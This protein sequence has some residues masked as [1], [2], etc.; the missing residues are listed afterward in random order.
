MLNPQAPTFDKDQVLNFLLYHATQETRLQLIQEL[1]AAYARVTGGGP[2]TVL[3]SGEVKA[4]TDEIDALRR[5][6]FPDV[7]LARIRNGEAA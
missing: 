2:Y 3:R 5:N 6:S 7:R 4:L 1:P